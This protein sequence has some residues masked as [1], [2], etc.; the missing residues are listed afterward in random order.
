MKS[1]T[2]QGEDGDVGGQGSILARCSNVVRV[3]TQTAR[4]QRDASMADRSFQ[5]SRASVFSNRRRFNDHP[6]DP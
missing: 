3:R 4:S 5:D 6:D 2:E 1:Y